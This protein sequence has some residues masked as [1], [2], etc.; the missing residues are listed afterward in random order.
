[1]VETSTLQAAEPQPAPDLVH[2]AGDP[3][4]SVI[5]LV[6]NQRDLIAARYA[7]LQSALLGLSSEIIIV[8]DGSI[9]GGFEVLRRLAE[10]DPQL[11]IVRLRRSFGRSAALV[12]G[13]ARARGALIVT[14]DTDGQTAAADIPRLLEPFEQGYDVVSGWRHNIRRPLYIS[15]ANRLIS[16]TTGVHLRDYGC[17]LKAYRASVVKDMDLYGDLY[18]FIP[19]IASWQGVQIAEVAVWGRPGSAAAKRGA[20]MRGLGVLL[21]LITVR[22]M[23]GYAARPMQSFGL[24]GGGLLLAGSAIGGYLAVVKIALGQDIGE[25]PLLLLAVLLAVLGIQFL[26]LGLLAE[27]TIRSYYEIQHKPIYLVRETIEAGETGE[28]GEV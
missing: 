7:E 16:A 13:F 3:A 5:L 27:L 25:R 14:L 8:D 17:P 23:Q 12:A 20:V 1:M 9:D 10:D 28:T 21:D 4:I 2:T 11:R 24:M 15:L 26:V 19:A 22:F 6:E 18:R